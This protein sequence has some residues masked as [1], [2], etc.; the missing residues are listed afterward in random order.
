VGFASA[1]KG[2]KRALNPNFVRYVYNHVDWVVDGLM[3][4][5]LGKSGYAGLSH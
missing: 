2:V 1:C 3:N 4:D 5:I